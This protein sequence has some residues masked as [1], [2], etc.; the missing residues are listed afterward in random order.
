MR[1]N[2]QHHAD[3]R[4]GDRHHRDALDADRVEDR[5]QHR[6]SRP[7]A[8]DPDEGQHRE[9]CD[10]AD[11]GDGVEDLLAQPG[12]RRRAGLRPDG[13]SVQWGNRHDQITPS[14][15]SLGRARL[16][17]S[18]PQPIARV[19]RNGMKRWPRLPT[20]RPAPTAIRPPLPS[21]PAL[22]WTDRPILARP[23]ARA[24]TACV[25]HVAC[26]GVSYQPDA[27]ARVRPPASD[28][29]DAP[30]RVR[31]PASDQPDAPARVRPSVRPP[32]T[33]PTRER[34][35]GIAHRARMRPGRTDRTDRPSLARRAGIEPAR[36]GVR[37]PFV[38]RSN[39]IRRR[40]FLLESGV[41]DVHF[42]AEPARG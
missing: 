42:G 2:R 31:P 20:A 30:A 6:P 15:G 40:T 8:D 37:N 38:I 17:P 34:R 12:D 14:G 33:R 4:P 23:T 10:V 36:R 1:L 25:A 27:P 41:Q 18:R 3:E 32:P 22:F 35:S 13:R 19:P 11:L 21:S 29:P 28:Q 24:P 9:M 5:H 7:L 39:P 16:R 26:G